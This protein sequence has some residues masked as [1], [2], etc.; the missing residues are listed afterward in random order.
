MQRHR[1]EEFH[2]L[3]IAAVHMAKCVTSVGIPNLT[4]IRPHRPRIAIGPCAIGVHHTDDHVVG[5]DG[6]RREIEDDIAAVELGGYVSA[7]I[8]GWRGVRDR[9]VQE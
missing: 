7:A 4:P 8:G 9:R 3:I 6:V 1:A 5:A 2:V